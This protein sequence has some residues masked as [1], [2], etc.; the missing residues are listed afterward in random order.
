MYVTDEVHLVGN[1]PTAALYL[2]APR[3][4]PKMTCNLPP[5]TVEGAFATAMVDFKMMRAIQD[6]SVTVPGEWV[7]G[8]RPKIHMQRNSSMHMKYAKQIK[9]FYLTLPKYLIDLNGG[10]V[11]KAYTDFSCGHFAT[12]YLCTKG[13]PRTL[14][15]YGFDSLLDF[16]LRS[17]TD[18]YL[19]S[20]RNTPTT[21][22]LTNNWRRVW[23]HMFKEF[24][25]VQFVLHARHD[26]LKIEKPDN[27]QIEVY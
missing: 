24:H 20:E 17:G 7:L 21:A 15:L 6:G 27:L 2:E 22:R 11:G 4:G 26:D 23:P 16:D 14:H 12:H 18:T 8:Y 19:F 3:K 5:F 13:K 10:D 9:E 1:G 25:D